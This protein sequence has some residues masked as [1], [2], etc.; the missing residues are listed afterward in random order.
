MLE[1]VMRTVFS[2]WRNS[3]FLCAVWFWKGAE[4]ALKEAE[5]A[6]FCESSGHPSAGRAASGW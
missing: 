5:E 4:D 3:P 2:L 1:E 6:N